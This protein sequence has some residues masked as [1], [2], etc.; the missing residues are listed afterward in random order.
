LCDQP[1]DVAKI[2]V[3]DVR[4]RKGRQEQGKQGSE[5]DDSDAMHDC[6]QLAGFNMAIRAHLTCLQVK[7]QYFMWE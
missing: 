7:V 6:L 2:Q 3:F 4:R 5:D 1:L